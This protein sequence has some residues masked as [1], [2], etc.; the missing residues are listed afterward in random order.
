FTVLPA[1]PCPSPTT[2]SVSNI[3]INTTTLNWNS[4]ANAQNYTWIVVPSGENPNT[5]VP[6]ATGTVSSATASVSGL[7]S[8]FTYDFF[9]KSSCNS[10]GVSNWS[11]P[12]SFTTLGSPYRFV[13]SMASGNGDGSSWANASDDLQK[14]INVHANV[15]VWVAA[16]TYKP[17]RPA[18][19]LDIID[20]QNSDN[21]FVLKNNVKVYGG[22]SGTETTLDQRDLTQNVSILSGDFNNNGIADNDDA[23]H[24]VVISGD[25]GNATLDGFT[26]T[27]GNA[28]GSGNI[29][30]NSN[31]ISRAHSGGINIVQSPIALRN[32]I[33][34]DNNGQYGGG[35]FLIES[36]AAIKDVH[37]KNNT[38]ESGAGIKLDHSA[39]AFTN[40]VVT[41]NVASTFGGGIDIYGTPSPTLTNV[42]V[43]GNIAQ[44]G[45]GICVN[46]STPSIKNTIVYGNNTGLVNLT[47]SYQ[48]TYLNSLVEGVTTNA[49]GNIDG[50]TD[51][52][53]TDMPDFNTA[54]F[55]GGDYTLQLCSPIINKGNNTH[56]SGSTSDIS[57]NSRIYN[58][59]VDLGAYE[60]QQGST[61]PTDLYA[62]GLHTTTVTL[63]WTS[64]SDLFDIEWGVQGFTQGSGTLVSGLTVNSYTLT[65]LTFDTTY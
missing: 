20:Q 30:V 47:P 62:S 45:G 59:T 25:L 2:L 12:Y 6:S 64:E 41:G 36:A 55:A 10:N 26:I 31:N 60:V 28:T 42:T 56:I 23:Y 48:V 34:T 53:F 44:T 4:I 18:D 1:L 27:G 65:N 8:E 13:K 50:A 39:V 5:A 46:E 24:V 63:G 54:P 49:N 9:I 16:G 52:M 38:S 61:A 21:A 40:L 7:I 58:G 3:G 33:I 43:S 19:N 14:M 17:I 35:I 57:G 32:L 15:E 29:S 51:P 11:A 22:F 37:V